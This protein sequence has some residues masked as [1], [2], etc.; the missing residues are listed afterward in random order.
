[1][2]IIQM[3]LVIS[4]ISNAVFPK[5]PLTNAAFSCRFTDRRAM[6]YFRQGTGEA[7][8]NQTPTHAVITIVCGQC[9]DSMQMLRQHHPTVDMEWIFSLTLRTTSLSVSIS[10]TNNLLP[11]RSNRLTEQIGHAFYFHSMVIGHRYSKLWYWLP[12]A[13]DYATLIAPTVL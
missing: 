7:M 6:F 2:N 3:V 4:F 12:H 11:C 9:P 8:F 5:M 10:C 1:M 13:C